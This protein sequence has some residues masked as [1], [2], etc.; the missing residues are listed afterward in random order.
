MW[1][2]QNGEQLVVETFDHVLHKLNI[3]DNDQYEVYETKNKTLMFQM[4]NSGREFNIAAGSS[5]LVD[6]NLID[7][8]VRAICVDTRRQTSVFH[9]I[10]HKQ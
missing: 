3:M 6:L 5:K 7:R 4:I 2:M 9:H 1:L 10:I 8:L